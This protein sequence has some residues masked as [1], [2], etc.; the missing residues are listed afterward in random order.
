M[1]YHRLCRHLRYCS[2]RRFRRLRLNLRLPRPHCIRCRYGS[3]WRSGSVL[4]STATDP[5]GTRVRHAAH[6]DP[7]N[8]AINMARYKLADTS[9]NT[10]FEPRPRGLC[11]AAQ[12]RRA[13]DAAQTH[14]PRHASLIRRATSHAHFRTA[15]LSILELSIQPLLDATSTAT[16]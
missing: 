3:S 10:A 4:K 2:H 7:A 16:R 1:C 12:K 11:G 14:A 5:G 8:S 15:V 9:I 6:H 13:V